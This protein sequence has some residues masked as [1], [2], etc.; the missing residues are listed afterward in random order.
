LS[1]RRTD[2]PSLYKLQPSGPASSVADVCC[3]A[4]FRT[5]GMTTPATRSKIGRRKSAKARNRGGVGHR[6]CRGLYGDLA[7]ASGWARLDR[8]VNEV[9]HCRNPSGDVA[10]CINQ[11]STHQNYRLRCQSS[12]DDLG[13]QCVRRRQGEALHPG[14][15]PLDTLRRGSESLQTPR[16]RGL[17]S[18]S[19]FRAGA[20]SFVCFGAARLLLRIEAPALG[21]TRFVLW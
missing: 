4:S 16:W 17:D 7:A 8:L 15:E 3:C 11:I 21:S 13:A 9:T 1:S 20:R 12:Q 10:D 2:L 14:G 18:N 6:R 5:P 19:R